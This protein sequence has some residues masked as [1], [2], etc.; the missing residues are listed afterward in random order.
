M[1]HQRLL[2][3]HGL[4]IAKAETAFRELVSFTTISVLAMDWVSNLI[5][6]DGPAVGKDGSIKVQSAPNMMF[7]G[8][9]YS[10]SGIDFFDTIAQLQRRSHCD[11]NQSGK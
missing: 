9:H 7:E 2:P 4:A 11:T 3:Q 8:A 10:V 6:N 5:V 1:H